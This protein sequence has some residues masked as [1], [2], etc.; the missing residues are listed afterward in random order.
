MWGMRGRMRFKD[1]PR[2]RSRHCWRNWGPLIW[3]VNI[4]SKVPGNGILYDTKRFRPWFSPKG[5]SQKYQCNGS[6][7]NY[8]NRLDCIFPVKIWHYLCW[9][10]SIL[11]MKTLFFGCPALFATTKWVVWRRQWPRVQYFILYL[12]NFLFTDIPE[13]NLLIWFFWCACYPI[14]HPY[15]WLW[16]VPLC[17]LIPWVHLR[18]HP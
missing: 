15:N 2:Q 14:L 16:Y 9:F 4:G 1:P 6:R 7:Y 5:E 11:F 10:Y 13:H 8:G 17:S 12:F 18:C 3:R